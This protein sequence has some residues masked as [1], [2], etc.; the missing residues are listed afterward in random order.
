MG[1]FGEYFGKPALGAGPVAI[2]P[3]W[4]DAQLG[5][6]V[7]AGDRVDREHEASEHG[8]VDWIETA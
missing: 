6:D 1:W 3:C 2:K 8:S 7:L 4:V 5:R